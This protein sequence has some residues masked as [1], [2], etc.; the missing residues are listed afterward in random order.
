MATFRWYDAGSRRS[1]RSRSSTAAMTTYT[2][3]SQFHQMPP[4]VQAADAGPSN[5][6]QQAR[7]TAAAAAKKSSPGK[8]KL[9]TKGVIELLLA[10]P[11]KLTGAAASKSSG[12]LGSPIDL[13]T[14]GET[15]LSA[16]KLRFTGLAD[17]AAADGDGL[18]GADGD[19]GR[20]PVKALDFEMVDSE[21]ER[22]AS[23]RTLANQM[24][25]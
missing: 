9:I 8:R 6:A 2:N 7:A 16:P 24:M 14:P 18:D 12:T 3:I 17:G 15:P 25:G 4:K 21:G 10:L 23:L 11:R 5:T 1:G 20:S 13:L 19:Q 22:P